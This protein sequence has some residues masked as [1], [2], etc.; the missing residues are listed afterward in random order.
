MKSQEFFKRVGVLGVVLGL[1]VSPLA[2]A[3]GDDE[4]DER[5]TTEQ[6]SDTATESKGGTTG[7]MENENK[8]EWEQEE[9]AEGTGNGANGD[10]TSS[11]PDDSGEVGV[12]D[13]DGAQ[14]GDEPD[15]VEA[16][17]AQ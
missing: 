13:R 8:T 12:E 4:A 7:D 6:E 16:D 10:E 17:Q 1:A 2:F 3:E 9:E 5:E 14:G 15:T 11:A